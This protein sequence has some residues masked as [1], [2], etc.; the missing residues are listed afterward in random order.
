MKIKKELCDEKED[1]MIGFFYVSPVRKSDNHSVD[2]FAT[3]NDEINFFTKKGIVLVL[4][5]VLERQNSNERDFV[6]P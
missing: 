6:K 2:F 4:V 5:L 1:I 3:V